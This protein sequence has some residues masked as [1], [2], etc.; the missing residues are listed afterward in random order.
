MQPNKFSSK[1]QETIHPEIQNTALLLGNGINNYNGGSS[2]WNNLLIN[3]AKEHI[4]KNGDFKKILEEKSV[5]YPEFFDLVD[6]SIKDPTINLELKKR[7][8][9]GIL[10]WKPQDVHK[11]WVSKF[12]GINRPILTT[13]FDYLL[14]M[15]DEDIRGFIQSNSR[16]ER[17]SPLN[18]KIDPKKREYNYYYPWRSYYSNRT[19]SD[20][21]NDFA[22]WHIHGFCDFVKSIRMGLS[23]YMGIVEK[24]R[25]ILYK[26]TGN[27][28]KS[29]DNLNNW[30]GR[31]TWLDVFLNNNIL[32][33]GLGLEVQEVSL[34]WLLIVREKLYKKYEN[35]GIRKKTW[36]ILNEEYDLMPEGKRL[37]F[38]K[39]NID[40][41]PAAKSEDIYMSLPTLI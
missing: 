33:V 37:F 35:Q 28:F 40:I 21:N 27:P 36:F 1:I 10:K 18:F 25:R 13:N 34:R 19:I 41:I 6:L 39:L 14:E 4:S 23:D 11:D 26:T 24:S 3:L 2:S 8:A 31:N 15:A 16:K 38:E 32:I 30:I 9:K 22:I 17:F 7:L 12:R 5:S 29:F 20:C